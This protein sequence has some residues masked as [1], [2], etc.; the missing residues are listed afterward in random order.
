MCILTVLSYQP[1]GATFDLDP[2]RITVVHVLSKRL[3]AE[4]INHRQGARRAIAIRLMSG[5][6]ALYWAV[7]LPF[8]CWGAWATPGHPHSSPHFVFFEPL[9]TANQPAPATH[10]HT[11]SARNAPQPALPAS[12]PVNT[13][14]STPTLVIML[15]VILIPSA[16]I[17]LFGWRRSALRVVQMLF[18][19]DI[20][21]P[22][23]TPPPRPFAAS[24]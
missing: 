1:K 17:M 19:G 8:I 2:G 20:V 23:S 21:L 5:L 6:L 24:A 13:G 15:L 14:Q 22:V 10:T 4:P 7:V 18:P 3:P 11:E 16:V 9:H 12:D